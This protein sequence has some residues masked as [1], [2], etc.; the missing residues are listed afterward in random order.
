MV[1]REDIEDVVSRWTGVPVA[2]VKE[3]EMRK[4]LRIEEEL[5]RRVIS[6]EKPSPPSPAPSAAAA[7]G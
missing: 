2:S 6:Q 4:L 3:E 1:G 7:P 5:H